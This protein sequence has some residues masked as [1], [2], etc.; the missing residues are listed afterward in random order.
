MARLYAEQR[1][2]SDKRLAASFLQVASHL[3]KGGSD[4][5]QGI[6]E[7]LRKEQEAGV[8][9]NS[10]AMANQN[11]NG[12]PMCSDHTVYSMEPRHKQ[13]TDLWNEWHGLDR[14]CD[15]Y[16]GIKGRDKKYKAK[17]RKHLDN[18]HY[19]RTKRCVL[20]IETYAAQHK[21]KE[22]EALVV[23]QDVCVEEKF[24]VANLVRRFQQDGYLSKQSS[25]GKSKK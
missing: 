9:D 15:G 7:L 24:S 11:D 22:E 3:V 17:W 23:L 12:N 20:G 19:S 21:I 16:G 13:L 5:L 8:T 18:Q 6:G 25:R 2:E 1:A 4:A 14:F 10:P